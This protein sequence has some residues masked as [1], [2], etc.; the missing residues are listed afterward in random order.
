[1]VNKHKGVR[2]A[3][4]YEPTIAE[5]CRKHNDANVLCLPARFMDNETASKCIDLFL[6]TQFEGGRHQKRVDKIEIA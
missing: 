2:G 1:V 4:C 6:A 3:L 5:M